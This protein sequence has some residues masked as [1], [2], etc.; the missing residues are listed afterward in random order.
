MSEEMRNRL[1]DAWCGPTIREAI[2]DLQSS[3]GLTATAG[4]LG[5]R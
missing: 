1:L 4:F 3:R 5:R 2:G